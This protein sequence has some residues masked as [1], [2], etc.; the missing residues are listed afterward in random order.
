MPSARPRKSASVASVTMSGRQPDA[1]DEEAVEEAAGGADEDGHDD[2]QL[3]RQAPVL[4][5]H[6]EHDGHEADDGA[7]REVDAAG[8][9]DERHGQRD[10]RDLGRQPTLV[11][12]VLGGQEDVRLERQ[13][14][15]ADDEDDEEDRLLAEQDALQAARLRGRGPVRASRSSSA[16]HL[17]PF[18]APATHDVREHRGTG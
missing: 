9:D 3:E 10:E 7:H 5:G 14:E 2:G 18:L 13:Q 12:E 15:D 1:R 11:E 8:D 17:Q 16:R 4:P 6:A